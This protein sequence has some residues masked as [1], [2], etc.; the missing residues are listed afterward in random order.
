M[1]KILFAA[2]LC[3]PLSAIAANGHLDVIKFELVEGCSLAEHQA[4][5]AD[6]NKWG[7]DHG[8]RAR[9]AVPIQNSDL[10]SFYW[11]GESADAATY[12]AAWDAWRDALAD[13]DSVPA[14]LAA[15]F[16]ECSKNVSRNGYDLY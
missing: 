6:F 13:S 15:R 5:T 3:L 11:L 10:N 2:L 8:Y 4:I 14:Q 12:G 9:V 16:A 7:A 1:K